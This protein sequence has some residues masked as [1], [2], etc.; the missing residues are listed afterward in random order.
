MSSIKELQKIITIA[1]ENTNMRLSHQKLQGTPSAWGREDFQVPGRYSLQ[2]VRSI[3]FLMAGLFPRCKTSQVYTKLLI[4]GSDKILL[5]F[6]QKKLLNFWLIIFENFLHQSSE[7]GSLQAS[8]S[9][10]IQFNKLVSL[11]FSNL[12]R[13]FQVHLPKFPGILCKAEHPCYKKS[14]LQSPQGCLI[15][16]ESS[17]EP[18]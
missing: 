3:T 10:L 8:F 16:L 9:Y 13:A 11:S 15:S 7:T 17:K 6:F 14:G 2:S 12:T 1:F 4:Y 18:R 5:V